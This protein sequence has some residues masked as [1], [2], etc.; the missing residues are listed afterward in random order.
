MTLSSIAGRLLKSSVHSQPLPGKGQPSD[1]CL[2]PERTSGLSVLTSSDSDNS[3][4]TGL[5]GLVG[6]NFGELRG[7]SK[8]SSWAKP[9]PLSDI[10]E[11][12]EPSLVDPIPQNLLSDNLLRSTSRTEPLRKLSVAS[13][14]RPSMDTRHGENR[15][16]D[17]KSSIESNGMRSV[18]RMRPSRTPSPPSPADNNSI[19]SIYS[20]PPGSVPP[21]L[22]S[23]TRAPN[24]SRAQQRPQRLPSHTTQH[25]P[26][27]N[28]LD[29]K[30]TISL[31]PPKGS[32]NTIPRRGHSQSPLRH[33]AARLDPITHETNRRIPSRTFVRKPLSQELLDFPSH[34]HP[35]IELGLDLSAAIF[36]GGGSIEGTA[37]I[38]VDDAER[39]RHRRTLDIARI[40]IDLLGLEEMSGNK[41]CVFLNLATEL[42][43]EK[44]PPPQ[45]MVD[46]QEPIGLEDVFWHL[47][48]SV[49]NLAFNLSLPLN[50]GPPPF[51]AKNTRIRYVLCVSLLIR[52]HGKQY[53]VRTSEDVTVLSVYDREY[54]QTRLLTKTDYEQPRKL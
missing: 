33:V 26:V 8:L 1:S 39:I 36:V 48:P 44:N 5:G 17:R 41:R 19:S 7:H 51:R 42:I 31:H 13:R 21:R 30:P 50:V 53:I 3:Q 18:H 6:D 43:D 25:L 49:T 52:D 20:I 37:Q 40:S 16:P 4:V 38:T 28:S 24:I 46:T 35:R 23:Q 27:T 29:M 34:R 47:M 14:Q 9:R 10:R 2:S 54:V 11:L 32:G 15:E 45:N 22:S 12:T